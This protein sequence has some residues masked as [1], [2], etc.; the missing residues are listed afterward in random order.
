MSRIYGLI[1]NRLPIHPQPYPD[2]LLSHWFFRLAHKN[3][4]KAQTLA[5]YA[6]GRY[7]SFWARDQDKLASPRVIE[8]LAD[9]TGK[10][11]DDIRAL[12]LASYEGRVYASH[13]SFGNNRWI[14]PLGIYHR[15]WRRFGLQY[16]PQCLFEDSEP[17]FRRH[18]RLALSTI[19]EKHGVLM[20]DRCHRCGAPVMYFRNDLGHRTRHYFK[21]SACC[22]ACGANLARAPA[23]DPPGPDGQ[24]LA[25]MRSLRIALDM[26][27]WWAGKQTI[28]FGH[29]FFDVLHRLATL[30]AARKGQKLLKEVERRIGMSAFGGRQLQAKISL[31]HRALVERHWLISMGL[32]LLQ[33]W[34]TRFVD[35][36]QAARMW[37]SWLIGGEHFPYWFEAVLDERLDRSR[38]IPNSEE[39]GNVARYLART[40]Q[41]LSMH[42]VGNLL[43]SSDIHV[44][45]AYAVRPI[46][47]WPQ[48][49]EGFDLLLNILDA[50]IRSLTAGSVGQLLAERDRVILSL[51]K[52]SGW[53]AARVLLLKYAD[54]A[55]ILNQISSSNWREL[56][57][58][59]LRYLQIIRPALLG[60]G[61]SDALF[62]GLAK[63]GISVEALAYRL[64]ALKVVRPVE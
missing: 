24:T 23:Y 14:L 37:Q 29:M 36:C 3:N 49:V 1:G 15:T 40:G 25:I 34:P 28:H 7:S 13:N 20:H 9:L 45:R 52:V 12:T 56:Q 11:P 51:M 10:S 2:E 54:R 21:S 19:C 61:K 64:K 46:G 48:T 18:W 60:V 30:L 47:R 63:E 26:G 41:A 22:H 4:L 31:E 38:Y 32:W 8:G 27:W 6:F 62:V 58:S 44:A 16:C 17:Y 39:A 57:W 33:D 42:S 43:G 5:D 59:F 50:R 35:T 55:S 53:E